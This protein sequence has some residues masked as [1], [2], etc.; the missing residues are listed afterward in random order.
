MTNLSSSCSSSDE[1][2]EEAE[3]PEQRLQQGGLR[4][5]T[6]SRRRRGHGAGV[7]AMDT[8]TAKALSLLPAKVQLQVRVR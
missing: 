3:G 6:S 1:M 2:Q 4:D 8:E 5:D 7:E